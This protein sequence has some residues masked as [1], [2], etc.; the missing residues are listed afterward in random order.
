MS[1]EIKPDG[2]QS[3]GKFK[4]GVSG[5]PGGKSKS[6]SEIIRIAREE[7]V[8]SVKKLA[9]IRDNPL[10]KPSEAAFA[11]NS[12]L[13]RGFGKPSQSVNVKLKDDE[14]SADQMSDE[15]I[16]QK[17]NELSAPK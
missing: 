11:S 15:Q 6:L 4:P 17:L 2:R 13:D 1:E 16:E 9:E 12:L 14:P 3:D 10:S 7:G 8:S 5:N